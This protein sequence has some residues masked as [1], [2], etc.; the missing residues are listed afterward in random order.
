[1]KTKRGGAAA[2]VTENEMVMVTGGF[3]GNDYLSST[4]IF[5][6]GKWEYGEELPVKLIGHCQLTSN[7]GVIVAGEIIESV[8][9]VSLW[10]FL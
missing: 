2:S 8:L 4:E 3:D 1:M 5:T 6:G 10:V 7:A 9:I